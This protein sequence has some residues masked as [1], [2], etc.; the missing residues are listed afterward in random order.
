MEAMFDFTPSDTTPSGTV[1]LMPNPPSP[2]YDVSSHRPPPSRPAPRHVHRMPPPLRLARREQPP[3]DSSTSTSVT[4]TS[5]RLV[6]AG[7]ASSSQRISLLR[8]PSHRRPPALV[9]SSR[10][11]SASSASASSGPAASQRR[12]YSAKLERENGVMRQRPA[13]GASY[14]TA[15]AADLAHLATLAA[16]A[17]RAGKG[18]RRRVPVGGGAA[19]ATAVTIAGIDASAWSPTPPWEAASLDVGARP[20]VLSS[21]ERAHAWAIASM[22]HQCTGVRTAALRAAADGAG[23]DVMAIADGA[24]GQDPWAH[25][26]REQLYSQCEDLAL[27]VHT[28]RL[29]LR[30]ALQERRAAGVTDAPTGIPTGPRPA[31]PTSIA[32][33]P[34]AVK[35]DADVPVDATPFGAAPACRPSARPNVPDEAAAEKHRQHAEHAAA[36]EVALAQQ[37]AEAR[38]EGER[39]RR[40]K[41]EA[42]AAAAEARAVEAEARAGGALAKL[43]EA[44]TKVAAAAAASTAAAAR[45][46]ELQEQA[47]QMQAALDA[48]NAARD[49]AEATVATAAA[50]AMP[51]QSAEEGQSE[52][53]R[54]ELA[55]LRAECDA[56]R[57]QLHDTSMSRSTSQSIDARGTLAASEEGPPP[58]RESG[59][60]IRY[61]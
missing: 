49:A 47:A 34:P 24:T 55:S 20:Q 44:E 18:G 36:Q 42:S 7:G 38:A 40:T 31:A 41:A 17:R 50:A 53:L 46:S 11:A 5:G 22:P 37:L 8:A 32:P 1:I 10:P 30:R 39:L 56:L 2:A 13:L 54:A 27:E 59:D 28:L 9:G 6:D 3:W 23:V 57:Q 12:E 26:T 43:T 29:T 35:G 21:C 45:V 33:A 15:D 48:A 52:M 51:V 60:V 61:G 4:A 19:A 25:L 16:A 58:P 14:N